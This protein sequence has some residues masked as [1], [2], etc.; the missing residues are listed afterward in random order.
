MLPLAA[1]TAMQSRR[2][3]LE[4]TRCIRRY[5]HLWT[6]D[7]I[8]MN[9]FHLM[10]SHLVPRFI[11]R[12]LRLRHSRQTRTLTPQTCNTVTRSLGQRC[13]PTPPKPTLLASSRFRRR[14][15]RSIPAGARRAGLRQRRHVPRAQQG[16]IPSSTLRIRRSR[17]TERLG[18]RRPLSHVHH[19]GRHQSVAVVVA[20]IM[21][22][23]ILMRC[24][25]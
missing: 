5:R 21:K 15:S 1:D 22:A 7:P 17:S 2:A 8:L 3:Y 18:V 10:G 13:C 12:N 16:T 19:L 14:T 24:T 9:P 23:K 6:M 25:I 11:V 4:S 20:R